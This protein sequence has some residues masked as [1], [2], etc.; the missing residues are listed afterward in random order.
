MIRLL[1]EEPRHPTLT[2]MLDYGRARAPPW[3]AEVMAPWLD[4]LPPEVRERRLDAL[5]VAT[6]VYAWKLLRRDMGRSLRHAA[7]AATIERGM[8]RACCRP[9]QTSHG[10]RMGEP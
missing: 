7:T 1:A 4:P 3:V 6:D 5:V 2:P 9:D 8:V 10:P